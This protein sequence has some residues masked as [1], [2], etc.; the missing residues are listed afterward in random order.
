MGPAPGT[1]STEIE[2]GRT[3]ALA[4]AAQRAKLAAVMLQLRRNDYD[5][6]NT[7]RVSSTQSVMSAVQELFGTTWPGASFDRL[8]QTFET[9]ERLF[10]GRLPGYHGVDTVYHDRQHTLDMTLA[11]ARLLAGYERNADGQT[12]FGAERA[13]MGI[14]TSLFHDA[15]YIREIH[16]EHANGAEFTLYHVTRSARFLA[17][18]LPKIGMDDWVPIAT[19]VV[20]FTGY[21]VDFDHIQLADRRDRK[22]GHLLGTADLIAQMADRCYLEKCRDRLYPEFVL[23]GVAAAPGKTGSIQVKYSSGLDL[24]RQTPQFVRST[25]EQRLDGEFAAA[26]RYLEHLFE[27]RNPYIESIDRNMQFLE[28]V[29][30]LGRWPLLRRNPPLFTSYENQL[31]QVRSLMLDHLKG[32]WALSPALA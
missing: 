26:Y 20:H 18:F 7:V 27:G 1:A 5:V 10:S 3:P 6:T 22:L 28:R 9:F 29:L 23:G 24:L 2:R 17:R 8:A 4:R 15:G 21:E 11:M 32:L 12:R 13:V 16:D 30:R 19:R 14:V 25:R 31:S